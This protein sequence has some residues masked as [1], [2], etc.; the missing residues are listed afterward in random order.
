YVW[1]RSGRDRGWTEDILQ[2]TWLVAARDMRRFEPARGTFAAWLKGIAENQLRNRR[3]GET[4]RR[5]LSLAE[6]DDQ[7]ATRDG[8]AAR[9]E[10]NEEIA[11]TFAELPTRY[12]DVLRAK[13][14]HQRPTAEIAKRHGAT[15]KS[16]ESLLGR[17]RAA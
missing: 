9:S 14:E 12:Q 8:N 17:A 10:L 13:Y 4:R 3:R 11:L 5:A 7:I 1:A 15:A 16:I 2:E 6:T